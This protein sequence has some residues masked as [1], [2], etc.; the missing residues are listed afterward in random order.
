MRIPWPLVILIA[1]VVIVVS[2]VLTKGKKQ[3]ETSPARP[4]EVV[5]KGKL[6]GLWQDLISC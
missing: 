1:V 6:N 3:D 5:I 4:G 2:A